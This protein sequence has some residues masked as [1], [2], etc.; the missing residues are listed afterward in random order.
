VFP[1]ADQIGE[2]SN[3]G[4]S[5]FS[6]S[7]NGTL[8]YQS[9]RNCDPGIGLA[10]PQREAAGTITKRTSST[11][12]RF[13]PM[14]GG[15][16]TAWYQSSSMGIFGL[17]DLAR[18][19]RPASPSA[20]TSEN[21]QFGLPTGR[22]SLLHSAPL[23]ADS[24]IYTRSR[25]AAQARSNCCFTAN[26][27]DASD[28]S[29]DGKLIVFCRPATTPRMTSGCCRWT[30]TANRACICRRPS[31]K[32]R[33]ILADGRWM[34]YSSDESGQFQVYVQPIPPNGASGRFERGRNQPRWRPD[35][36]EL[37]YAARIGGWWRFR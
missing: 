27:R 9:G 29:R 3:T 14:N 33:P 7:W 22:A 21:I 32:T 26:Q 37:F 4:F 2:A 6:A 1:L 30:E 18:G 34:A 8:V 5:A 16:P 25:P 28:W 31:T 17:Q 20:R 36:K 11:A 23:R 13:R 12:R 35:G 19:A 15:W 10:G 24:M